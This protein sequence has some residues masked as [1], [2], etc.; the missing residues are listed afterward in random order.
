MVA[1]VS[2][3]SGTTLCPYRWN[4]IDSWFRE[5]RGPTFLIVDPTTR[6]VASR[7][8]FTDEAREAHRFGPLTVYLFGYDLARYFP[9]ARGPESLCRT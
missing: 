1:P 4:T 2:A 5:R 6:F 3:G 9:A 7:P 8:T